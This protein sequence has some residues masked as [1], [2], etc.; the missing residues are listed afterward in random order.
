MALEANGIAVGL[1]E[2]VQGFLDTYLK[3]RD[4]S[5]REEENRQRRFHNDLMAKKALMDYDR[6]V[7]DPERI[8]LENEL[9]KARIER[10]K[11]LT[12]GTAKP[13]SQGRENLYQAQADKIRKDLGLLD[14][15]L[16][17]RRKEA[18]IERI[19]ADILRLQDLVRTPEERALGVRSKKQD[20][21]NDMIDNTVRTGKEAR[22][23]RSQEIEDM[24]NV[25][26][27]LGKKDKRE[28]PQKYI[29]P[30]RVLSPLEEENIKNQMEARKKQWQNQERRTNL[31]A[32][33][34]RSSG[35]NLDLDQKKIVEALATATAKKQSVKNNLDALLAR[36]DTLSDDDK[37]TQGE[38]ILKTLNSLEGP[39]AISVDDTKRLGSR[40]KFQ[41]FN[42]LGV[43]PMFGRDLPGFKK[44]MEITSKNMA[45][46]ISMN[47]SEIDKIYGRPAEG[48]A[49]KGLLN[50]GLLESAPKSLPQKAGFKVMIAP[51]GKSKGKPVYIPEAQVEKALKAGG[52]LVP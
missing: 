36:W 8:G 6:K 26:D 43:G 15:P 1:S 40:L 24:E 18:D 2:G 44:Q 33:K 49:A 38:Q 7:K 10:A 30:S 48:G 25:E 27:I 51:S 45:D 4:L 47:K 50:N 52:K 12:A 34:G 42:M 32:K 11:S 17:I 23:G 13:L 35:R 29:K 5:Q 39:D 21:V 37:A 9:L 19:K 31:D 20:I 16:T 14:D 28:N 41:M 46:S 3:M 22:E